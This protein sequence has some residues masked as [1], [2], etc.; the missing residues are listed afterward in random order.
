MGL[1]HSA[2][3]AYRGVDLAWHLKNTGRREDPRHV[4]VVVRGDRSRIEV[5]EGIAIGVPVLRNLLPPNAGLEDGARH[6]LEIVGQ[7]DR[8]Y[9]V[10]NR[11]RHTTPFA[12]AARRSSTPARRLSRAPGDRG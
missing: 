8:L 3:I 6:H 7:R 1:E 4:D 5:L 9:D 2:G 12:L 10:R 11:C